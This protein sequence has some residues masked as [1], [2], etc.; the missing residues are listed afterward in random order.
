MKKL[1]GVI[2]A[3][4][5]PFNEKDQVDVEAIKELTDFLIEKGVHCLYPTGTTG[6]M[7]LMSM[8]ERKLVAETVVNKAAGKVNVFIHVGAMTTADTITLAKHAQS[9]GADGIGIVTPSYFSVSDRALEEYFVQV[10]SSVPENFPVYLYGIPQC[11]ANDITP[12]VAQRVA[13]KCKNIIGIKYSYPDMLRIKDYLEINN[14]N[15]S[16]VV[17]TDRLFYPALCM[18]CDGTVSGVSCSMPEHFVAVYNAYQAK[19]E[20]IA[21]REQKVANEICEILKNGSDMAFFKANLG[22]RG[23]KGGYMR[24][25]LLDLTKAEK[26]DLYEQIK[27]Y[28]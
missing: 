14:G 1:Y 26:H 21:R 2:T 16:V 3:M 23:I 20:A 28:L 5:T 18:G 27:N 7:Y 12:E 10:A 4:T 13:Q 9:I 25:P 24:K 17:G 6:E 8:E 19:D 22:F 11:S 15:F